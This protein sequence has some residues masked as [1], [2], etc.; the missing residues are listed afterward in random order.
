MIAVVTTWTGTH[1]HPF[2]GHIHH[3]YYHRLNDGGHLLHAATEYWAKQITRNTHVMQQMSTD[4]RQPKQAL[5]K[6]VR[7]LMRPLNS[8]Q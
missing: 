1:V 4:Y 7:T 3:H 8:Y 5:P 2:H 6:D